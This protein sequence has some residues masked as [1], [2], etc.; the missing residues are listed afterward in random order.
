MSA[1]VMTSPHLAVF[2][3]TRRA[4]QELRWPILKEVRDAFQAIAERGSNIEG[5][6]TSLVLI[7]REHASTSNGCQELLKGHVKAALPALHWYLQFGDPLPALRIMQLIALLAPWLPERTWFTRAL[8]C[9]SY[10][11]EP[12]LRAA[13]L[14]ALIATNPFA[15]SAV[16]AAIDRTNDASEPVRAKALRLCGIIG[17][18]LPEAGIASLERALLHPH[19]PVRFEGATA[20]GRIGWRAIRLTS[21][22]R[23]M[24]ED[25][26]KWVRRAAG[27]ALRE[28][29]VS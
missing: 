15:R 21:Q 3:T 7:Y 10:E 12:P 27:T 5:A 20:A 19:A 6:A 11:A 26:S 16:R 14:D 2:R 1:L 4:D 8:V 29:A 23:L 18:E 9:L 28:L 13:A 17:P 25:R 22:L 24:L